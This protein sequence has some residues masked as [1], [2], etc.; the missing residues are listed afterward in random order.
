M[1]N[2]TARLL[3]QVSRSDSGKLLKDYL[4]DDNIDGLE[5]RSGRLFEKFQT[6]SGVDLP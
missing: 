2:F 5:P 3:D 4:S 6:I 1:T